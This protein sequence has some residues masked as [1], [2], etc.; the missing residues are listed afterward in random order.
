M[1][2]SNFT[3]QTSPF[4]CLR[5][6]HRQAA[7]NN[8]KGLLYLWERLGEGFGSK[9]KKE[10]PV[11]IYRKQSRKGFRGQLLKAGVDLLERQL[12]YI[13]I[14]RPCWSRNRQ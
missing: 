3:L 5:A 10:T 7:G 11:P 2:N 6:T 8:L 13:Q 4:A 14:C 9:A 12:F 1:N